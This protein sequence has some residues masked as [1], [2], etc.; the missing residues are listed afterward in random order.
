MKH[1]WALR[2]LALTILS[3]GG[4]FSILASAQV[5]ARITTPKE[6]FGFDIGADYELANYE[7]FVGYMKKLAGESDRM[8]LVDIGLTAEGRH[9][10]MAIIT[11]PENQKNLE[12]YREISKQLALADGL[13]DDQAHALAHEGKAVIFM[14]FGIHSTETVPT[15]SINEQVYELLSQS[16]EETMRILNDDIILLCF[17]NPDGLD[18]VASWY[19]READPAKRSL[20]GLPTLFNKYIGHDDARDMFMSNMPESANMNKV[21]WVDWFPQITHT[22]HEPGLAGYNGFV[23]FMPPFRDPFN[24]SF[25]PLIPVDVD[26]LGA[27]MHGWLIAR[28]MPGSAMKG[29]SNY[30]TWWNGGMRTISYFH[31]SIGLLTEIVGNPTPMEIPLVLKRQLADGNEPMPIAPQAWHFRQPMAYE[32]QYDRAVYDYASRNRETLLYDSYVM[33]KRQIERGSTDSWI[34]TPDSIAAAQAAADKEEGDKAQ[35][36]V[37][38]GSGPEAV[39]II[40]SAIYNT[41]LHSPETRIPRGYILS[42]DQPDYP[43]MVK[44]INVLLKNGIAVQKATAPFQVAG[45]SY[46]ANSYIVKTAQSPL[47]FVLD[48]FE[49]QVYPNDFQYPGGPPIPPYDIAGWTLAYQMDL[50]FD[51]VPDNFT[52]PFT[53]VTDLQK[54]VPGS[55]EGPSN[56]A[57]YLISHR[58]NNSFILIN[59]L[60]KNN[61]DVY[62]LK[63][64][65]AADGEDLGTGAIWVPASPAAAQVLE[66]GAK[67]LGITVHAVATAP[68]GAALKLKPIRVGLYDQYGGLMPSGWTRWILETYEFPATIV[69]PQMLDAGNLKSQF[70][71]LIFT[72]GAAHF[73]SARGG[74]E[75]HQPSPDSIPEQYRS[76]LGTITADKTIPQL[77]A[78]VEAGGSIVTIGSSTS[79]AR[80]LGVPVDNY[81]TEMGPNGKPRPLSPEKFYIPG[82]VMKV[83]INN[84]DPLAYG[85]PQTVDVDFDHSPVFRLD[86]DAQLK[87]AA[88]VAWFS[89]PRTLQSGWAW[90]Q[91]YLDGGTAILDSSVGAGK[92][93]VLGPE[94]AFR[95]QAQGTYKFLFNSLYYGSADPADLK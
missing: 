92:V 49:P 34:V 12:H 7:Q 20:E 23:V 33:G 30:S 5:D 32:M 72:D 35:R 94:V 86:P 31:N 46:P 50:K 65:P 38:P 74:F 88:P 85:M 9:Q 28:D 84:N 90:G 10:Y 83:S 61:A 78:F 43:T 51:P 81:L 66:A 6:Q 41:V 37:I 21:M 27:A 87:H 24:Y 79:M 48:M 64:A 18:K 69:R 76:W 58:V 93:F 22:H 80:L 11:S 17:A 26:A 77:K 82:S 95:G 75:T 39:Q 16:D 25:D 71:V 59:R 2:A 45:K 29:A 8:K 53:D 68:T 47:P 36:A 1:H 62:W 13:S 70:D 15:Q 57:G 63:T 73:G 4:A 67:E 60:L 55:I 56:P 14:D 3:V 89:G 52:G 91:Q 44:F 40:P 42:A 19:M 54:P